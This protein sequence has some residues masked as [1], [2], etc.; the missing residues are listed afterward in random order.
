MAK[1]NSGKK[2][3]PATWR[4]VGEAKRKGASDALIISINVLTDKFGFGQDEVTR[5]VEGIV[6]LMDSINSGRVNIADLKKVQEEEYKI[7]FLN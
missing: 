2:R 6:Y 1:S 4:D 3:P 7:V 5:F